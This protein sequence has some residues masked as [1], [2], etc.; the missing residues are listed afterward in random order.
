MN[1]LLGLVYSGVIA[2]WVLALMFGVHEIRLSLRHWYLPDARMF[3]WK[4][5]G[6]TLFSKLVWLGAGVGIIVVSL[7]Q[8]ALTWKAVLAL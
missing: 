1:I 5:V 3:G 4:A 6:L 8:I 2:C 7:F